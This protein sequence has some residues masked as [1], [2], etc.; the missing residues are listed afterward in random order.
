MGKLDKICFRS[1]LDLFP[2]KNVDFKAV[3]FLVIGGNGCRNAEMTI[4]VVLRC[5]ITTNEISD[6]Y[7]HTAVY[8]T[9]INSVRLYS[10][11]FSW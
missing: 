6:N 4:E 3:Q 2:V 1:N 11:S 8:L 10:F 9:V 5:K 7:H